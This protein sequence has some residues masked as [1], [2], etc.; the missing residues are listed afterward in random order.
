MITKFKVSPKT[1][2]Q[3]VL[4]LGKVAW[5]GLEILRLEPGETWQGELEDE[6][7]ALIPLSG[8]ISANIDSGKQTQFSGVG[9]RVDVFSGLP[10]AVYAPRKSKVKITAE[11]KVELA[12]V[13]AP[14]DKDLPPAV[15]KP[16]DVK[17]VSAGMANWRRDV[18]LVVAPG[19]AISQRL[20]V[21]ETVNPSGNWSG[22][23]PHKH[24]EISGKENFLEEFYWFKVKPAN[25]Y[26]VQ[27]GYKDNLE[28]SYIIN[29]D[30]VY[31][32]QNGYH[33]TVAAPGTTLCYLWVLSG[34]DKAYNIATDPRFDWVGSAEAVL[35]EI[36]R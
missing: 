22:I 6:E 15:V 28:E 8:R 7:C 30:D 2:H 1:G 20:I 29:N 33:P 5:L 26:G 17:V 24:D 11:T 13:K 27:L 35:R 34:D 18:R 14:C 21:G 10:W 16:E 23:P 19:A 25:G 9:G 4:E 36:Q 3:T 32:M 31:L 12:L